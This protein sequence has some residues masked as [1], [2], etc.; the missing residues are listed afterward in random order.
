LRRVLLLG[1]EE[2]RAFGERY[3]GKMG[4]MLGEGSKYV[5]SH[6]A[7]TLGM[8]L[9]FTMRIIKCKKLGYEKTLVLFFG[10]GI[11]H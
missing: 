8:Q 3:Y 7:L 11:L 5:M 4:G 2:L 9:N 10:L 6:L 1:E